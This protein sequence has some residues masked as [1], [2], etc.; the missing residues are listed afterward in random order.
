MPYSSAVVAVSVDRSNQLSV[1]CSYKLT[2]YYCTPRLLMLEVLSADPSRLIF[3]SLDHR[4]S[5]ADLKR[6]LTKRYVHTAMFSQK[7]CKT[8]LCVLRT[9]IVR[10]TKLILV[11][12]YPVC[13][14]PVAC[15]TRASR[16]SGIAFARFR[17]RRRTRHYLHDGL[18]STTLGSAR[19]NHT[20]RARDS[21]TPIGR[22][23]AGANG[24]FP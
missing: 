8:P 11:T 16:S 15:H 1:S 9:H 5:V 7:N 14:R 22:L 12:L 23:V 13:L 4:Y 3:V 10:S 6:R 18:K 20:H 17:K 21:I 19:F 24:R 2:P